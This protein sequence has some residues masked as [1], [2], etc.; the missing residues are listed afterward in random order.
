MNYYTI[1]ELAK[2]SGVSSRTLRHYDAIG[3]LKPVRK[4]E[5]GYRLYGSAEVDRLQQ[6]LL[7]KACGF[8][9]RKISQLI[10][11]PNF[12]IEQALKTQLQLIADQQQNLDK[13]KQT[14]NKT[15]KVVRG[16]TKMTDDQ[17]FIGLKKKMIEDNDAKYG[18]EVKR[19]W[20]EQAWQESNKKLTS[21]TAQDLDQIQVLDK[22]FKQKLALAYE[23]GDPTGKLAQ[24]AVELHR[25]W[26]KYYWTDYSKEAHLGLA[27][28]Y[29]QDERF[30]HYFDGRMELAEFLREAVKLA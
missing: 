8:E 3:L 15:I 20:G 1:Q 12:D 19:R 17:K 7:Y 24:Q 16:T 22:E 4:N 21:L 29:C 13:I 6:I 10:N 28:V 27:E 11:S 9:L 2:L 30:A 18:E 5:S 25:Q 23:S 26:L 14:I